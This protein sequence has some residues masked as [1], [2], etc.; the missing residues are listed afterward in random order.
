MKKETVNLFN[1]GLNYDLNPLTT[2]NDV[3]TDCV[4]GTFITFN[5]DE[6]I[7]QNDAGNTKILVPETDSDPQYV[8]L[9]EGF[10]PIGMKEYGGILYIVSTD[11]TNIEFGSYPSPEVYKWKSTGN[12]TGTLVIADSNLA[13]FYKA[14]TLNDNLFTAGTKI[15]FKSEPSLNTD[16]TKFS[17]YTLSGEVLTKIKRLYNLR[18]VQLLENG[19]IDLTEDVW[20]KF[21]KTTPATVSPALNPYWI[22]P[23]VDFVYNC[24]NNFKGKLAVIIEIE[25]LK[26]FK[27]D[28]LMIDGDR[29]LSIGVRA[30]NEGTGSWGISKLKLEYYFDNGSSVPVDFNS[31]DGEGIWKITPILVPTD[32]KSLN[33]TIKPTF[34]Y[35]S[36]PYGLSEFP[37]EFSSKY[38]LSGTLDIVS[39]LANIGI[40]LRLEDQICEDDGVNPTGYKTYR[41]IAISDLEGDKINPFTGNTSTDWWYLYN[42]TLATI[43]ENEPGYCGK[44]KVTNIHPFDIV[45]KPEVQNQDI[46]R[47]KLRSLPVRTSS[48]E[49]WGTEVTLEFTDTLDFTSDTVMRLSQG[50]NELAVSTGGTVL[51]TR[52]LDVTPFIVE[53]L[54]LPSW[55]VP[56]YTAYKPGVSESTTFKIAPELRFYIKTEGV[57]DYLCL[58][59]ELSSGVISVNVGSQNI[60]LGG[61]ENIKVLIGTSNPSGTEY[62]LEFIGDEVVLGDFLNTDSSPSNFV[63]YKHPSGEDNYTLIVRKSQKLIS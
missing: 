49:C 58:D 36:I 4:N 63:K 13:N 5:G 38:I 12:T 29:N 34:S 60:T 20:R 48:P 46:L 32:A 30:S 15:I 51:T 54:W 11:G 33:Y 35:N 1:K 19:E 18:L 45:F 22:A 56:N 53:I 25:D 31:P 3:L 10:Y 37:N 50:G 44:F 27:L 59:R 26:E 2:P 61:P 23:A 40:K 28:S 9:S 41:K 6:L 43:S 17:A 42:E 47:S 24:P 57:S 55:A 14:F 21:L 39:E 62:D 52:I 16:L 7:L 8:Q